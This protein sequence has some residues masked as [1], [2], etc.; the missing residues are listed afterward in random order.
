MFDRLLTVIEELEGRLERAEAMVEADRTYIEARELLVARRAAGMPE[1]EDCMRAER[2][3][4]LR[5]EAALAAYDS[6]VGDED[7]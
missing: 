4:R 3:A 6:E 7:A 5:R 1:R 2:D